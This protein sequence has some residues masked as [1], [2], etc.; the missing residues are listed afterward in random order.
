M[1]TQCASGCLT[2]IH[3]RTSGIWPAGESFAEKALVHA[4]AASSKAADIPSVTTMAWAQLET[5][6]AG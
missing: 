6:I 4:I 1:E 3:I 5:F 2:S